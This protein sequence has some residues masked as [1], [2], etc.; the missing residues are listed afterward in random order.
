V[1]RYIIDINEELTM[2]RI[3]AW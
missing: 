3:L 1:A 2:E